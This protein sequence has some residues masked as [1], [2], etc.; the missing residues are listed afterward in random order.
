MILSYHPCY[1]GDENRL[2][3][4]RNPDD[5]DAAAM[6]Q[7]DAVILPQG[8]IR[9]LFEMAT[10]NCPHVFPDYTFRFGFPGKIGQATLFR[11][12]G[13]PHPQ[14]MTFTSVDHFYAN[15]GT[16]FGY[17][18]VFKFSWSGEG[19]NVWLVTNPEE[20][21]R[22]IRK[23]VLFESTGQQ[24]FL[25]QEHIETGGRSLR[26]VII[27][28]TCLS[29]WR[30]QPDPGIFSAQSAQGALL[31][32]DSDRKLQDSAKKAVVDFCR[33]TGINLAGF[34]MLLSAD[35]PDPTPL[36]LE[37]NYYFG[38]KGLGGSEPF[39]R[40]LCGEIDRWLSRRGIYNQ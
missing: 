33:K 19:D 35:D 4:G 14:T 27:G 39:Y 32:H 37:I 15:F 17:P 1:V 2:C 11:K 28:D 5:T 29:Y 12:Y 31:D 3:A 34:D 36:F 7:A 6:K 20:F 25:I 10:A 24:G 18:F 16:P 13:I 21:K 40:L 8:C 9:P 22:L 26:V 23:A 30:V 38:R